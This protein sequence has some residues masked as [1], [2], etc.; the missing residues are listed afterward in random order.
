[1]NLTFYKSLVVLVAGVCFWG[2]FLTSPSGAQQNE[3]TEERTIR[4]TWVVDGKPHKIPVALQDSLASNR[5]RNNQ[6]MLESTILK[7]YYGRGYLSAVI[8]SISLREGQEK[9]GYIAITRGC[10]YRISSFDWTSDSLRQ[11][12]D[13]QSYIQPKTPYAHQTVEREIDRIVDYF[14][15]EGYPLVRVRIEDL[16]R[17]PERC[18][19]SVI[20]EVE[21]GPQMRVEGL[22]LPSLKNVDPA[23]IRTAA[24]VKD[25]AL[26]TPELLTSVRERL[27][28]TGFFRRVG[29]PQIVVQDNKHYLQLSLEERNPNLFDLVIGYN[30][31]ATGGGTIVGDGQLRIRN[32]FWP[33]STTRLRFERQ[34][35]LVTKLNVGFE[36]NWIMDVPFGA[37]IHFNFLQQ[38]TSYQVRDLSLT[39]SYALTS[40]M[41]INGKVR[42]RVSV[43]NKSLQQASNVL[44]AEGLY[45]GLG[46]DYQRVDDPLTP[47]RGIE[48]WVDL[49]TGVKTISDERSASDQIDDRISQR[50][51][52]FEIQPYI[53][54]FRRQVL[55]LTAHGFLLD[56]RQMTESDLIRFGGTQSLRGYREDQFRA[57]R[58]IWGDLEYRYLIDPATYGFVFGASGY[59][60]RPR[61]ITESTDRNE[62]TDWL[63]SWGLGF[64]YQT[65]IGR[66]KFSYAVSPDVSL[67]NGLVHFGIEADL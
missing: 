22:L 6:G 63:Y 50:I 2:A 31:Q 59:Y 65:G 34:R 57:S 29:E 10:S 32:I 36:R 51:F 46:I 15:E 5:I 67:S 42:R 61:L 21:P 40:N 53:S 39:G 24:R 58:L 27:Q 55:T 17:D 54:T 16:Q 26:I 14:E 1:M 37:G 25:S 41:T 7:Y 3:E 38:D 13:A 62:S 45:A 35:R 9:A 30:P 52:E 64:S 18:E 11:D 60:R 19:V 49:Q 43:G 8:D 23:Y 33:G 66:L 4:W 44:D 56:A 28:Q 48:M 20:V 12:A 47:T